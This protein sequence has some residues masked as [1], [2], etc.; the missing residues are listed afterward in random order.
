MFRAHIEA[1]TYNL[2]ICPLSYRHNGFMAIYGAHNVNTSEVHRT[3]M[4]NN[5]HEAIMK[6]AESAC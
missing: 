3:Y 4:C 2:K 6:V 1:H 5:G